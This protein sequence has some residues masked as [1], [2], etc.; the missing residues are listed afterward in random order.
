MV[1]RASED[2]LESPEPPDLLEHVEPEAQAAPVECQELRE[3]PAPL[4]CPE[5]VEPPVPA[6]L[7]DPLAMLAVLARL[8]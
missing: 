8:V 3:E 4:V 2:R 7:V 6:A 5:T 1:R